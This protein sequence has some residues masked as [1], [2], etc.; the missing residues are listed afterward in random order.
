MGGPALSFS[1]RPAGR[2]LL[3]GGAVLSLGGSLGAR[4][5]VNALYHQHTESGQCGGAAQRRRTPAGRRLVRA[6]FATSVMPVEISPHRPCEQ[7]QLVSP[8]QQ[9]FEVLPKTGSSHAAR[10]P[11][12]V[13]P[14]CVVPVAPSSAFLGAFR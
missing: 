4:F 5:P 11:T 10:R 1:G 7:Y 13:I 3:V 8:G 9:A 2:F 6:A 14:G 12:R